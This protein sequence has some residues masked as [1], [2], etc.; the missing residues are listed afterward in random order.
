[1]PRYVLLYHE[2]PPGYERPS[3]WDFMLEVGERLRTWAL[4]RLP[5]GWEAARAAT[6]HVSPA[7]APT[8]TE[9]AVVA[10][11]LADHRIDYLHEEGPLTG[12]RGE[13]HRIDA[14]D[15]DTIA[16]NSQS[17]TLTLYGGL[18]H[19]EVTL[20]DSTLRLGWSV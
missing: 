19:G 4:P 20:R 1:M 2:C 14:G 15:F 10:T 13:V 6:A 8:S 18:V 7:C 11:P 17:W 5:R 3:H 9:S 12:N 16:E